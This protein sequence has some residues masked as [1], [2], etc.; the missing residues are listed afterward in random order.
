MTADP[1][2]PSIQLQWHPGDTLITWTYSQAEV[3][4]RYPVPPSTVIAWSN[5]P[6]VIVVEAADDE[7]PRLDNAVV[8]EPDGTERLR[9]RPPNVAS[10]PSHNLGFY[11]VYPDSTS[12]GLI[13]VFSTR[14]GDFWG[15][16]D[17]QTGELNNVTQWR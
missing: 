15:R 17:L 12:T 13:A 4:K 11:A 7:R 6:C 1:P 16:P 10:E 5:P 14:S 3:V 8:F 9:L 2:P